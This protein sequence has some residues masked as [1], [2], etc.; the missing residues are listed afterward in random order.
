M[1]LLI[2]VLIIL[3]IV[4]YAFYLLGKTFKKSKQG[5]CAACDFDCAIKQQLNKSHH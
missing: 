4:A 1:K 5:K 3:A 2:N